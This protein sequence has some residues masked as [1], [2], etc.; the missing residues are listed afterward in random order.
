MRLRR[1]IGW[2]RALRRD[3]RIRLN[4]R[5]CLQVAWYWSGDKAA[6]ERSRG[7]SEPTE[8]QS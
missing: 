8:E 5:V 3:T 6:W 7:V 1:A 4:R 2:Y